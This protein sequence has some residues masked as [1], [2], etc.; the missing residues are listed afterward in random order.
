MND[1]VDVGISTYMFF[2]TIK[3]L[4]W[5]M[6]FAFLVFGVFAFASNIKCADRWNREPREFDFD[7]IL[8]ISLNPKIFLAV[9]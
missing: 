9:D 4:I 7:N 6:L 3:N 5:L 2:R 8:R 1:I